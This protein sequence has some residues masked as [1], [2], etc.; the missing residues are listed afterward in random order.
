MMAKL[1]VIERDNNGLDARGRLQARQERARPIALELRRGLLEQRQLLANADVTAKAI[2]Y[3]LRR[4]TALT[5]NL[6]D[7]AVSIDRNAVENSNRP[8]AQRHRN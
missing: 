8:L 4:W 6:D 7:G 5:R 2:D 3:S 1:C